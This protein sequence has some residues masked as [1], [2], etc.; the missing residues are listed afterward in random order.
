MAQMQGGGPRAYPKDDTSRADNAADG[1]F[2]AQ[3]FGTR[4]LVSPFG[5][6]FPRCI[7]FNACIVE[8]SYLAL[9]NALRRGLVL[10]CSRLIN[11]ISARPAAHTSSLPTVFQG[12]IGGMAWCCEILN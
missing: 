4:C 12:P 11:D 3:P 7:L 6:A 1:L 9:K 5:V 10:F 2:A 8:A